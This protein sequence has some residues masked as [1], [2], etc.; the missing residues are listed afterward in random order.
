MSPPPSEKGGRRAS[1][2]APIEAGSTDKPFR[3]VCIREEGRAR[4]F[5]RY[6]TRAD[7]EHF[8]SSLNRI[9]CQARVERDEPEFGNSRRRFLIAMFMCNAVP[10]ARVVERIAA[11]I[12]DEL[13]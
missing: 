9:G 13:Q 12:N 6:S 7:A 4:I 1:V 5:G 3:V 2:T 8:A 11:E 10:G